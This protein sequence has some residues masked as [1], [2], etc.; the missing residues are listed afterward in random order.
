MMMKTSVKNTYLIK[1]WNRN[2]YFLKTAQDLTK[3]QIDVDCNGIEAE[4][5]C[6]EEI[7]DEVAGE[8]T[9]APSLFGNLGK[10]NV[11]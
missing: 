8:D 3:R 11:I 2:A 10:I 5:E 7:L 4:E 6:E 9:T 1:Q